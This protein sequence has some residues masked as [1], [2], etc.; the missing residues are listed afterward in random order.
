LQLVRLEV[1]FVGLG[2]FTFGWSLAMV[3]GRA[4]ARLERAVGAAARWCAAGPPVGQRASPAQ[5]RPGEPMKVPINK[6]LRALPSDRR[7][8]NR[9]RFRAEKAAESGVTRDMRLPIALVG[10]NC[11]PTIAAGF[12]CGQTVAAFGQEFADEHRICRKPDRPAAPRRPDRGRRAA[13]AGH[14]RPGGAGRRCGA[15]AGKAGQT[16][17]AFVS[18]PAGLSRLAFAGAGDL[19]SGNRRAALERAAGAL[20]AKY[21]T[22]GEE[23]LAI[24]FAGSG[25]SAEGAGRGGPAGRAPAFVAVLS[26]APG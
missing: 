16:F 20:V 21:L 6:A 12:P 10:R 11:K 4:R 13:A 18:G 24:D 8:E 25:L 2:R 7:W 9:R 26:I 22:S 23:T 15:F 19:A 5:M 1:H 14:A 3:P 17:E